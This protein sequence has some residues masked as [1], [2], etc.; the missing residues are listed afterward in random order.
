MT[1]DSPDGP[2]LL[3]EEWACALLL[4]LMVVLMFAQA[5]VRNCGPMTRTALG[6]WLAHASEVLPSGLTWLTFLA[7]S[8]VTRR[9]GLLAVDL[10]R[11]RLSRAANRRLEAVVWVLWG[12]FFLL[13]AVLGGVA[14]YAQRKQMTSLGWLPAW[15]VAMSIPCG[16]ALVV[17][18]TAQ[19]LRDR[20][21]DARAGGSV[22]ET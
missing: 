21:R 19:N 12:A 10:L 15:A 16:A 5:L 4:A 1:T 8:A 11:N 13:L 9:N 17:W 3:P 20:G 6:A 2:E 7:C 14:T 18:R 22:E